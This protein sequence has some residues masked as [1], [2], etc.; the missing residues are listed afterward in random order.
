M[1]SF[2]RA[3]AG[4]RLLVLACLVLAGLFLALSFQSAATIGMIGINYLIP[5]GFW[6][7]LL[8]VARYSMVAPWWKNSMGRMLVALDLAVAL[9][10]LPSVLSTE[11]GRPVDSGFALRLVMLDLLIIPATILSRV[12]LLERLH[13]TRARRWGRSL[14]DRF[15]SRGNGR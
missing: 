6:S 5:V 3:L 12:W 10:L 15:R 8:F 13:D 9:A 11:F 4:Y 1:R 2:W 7:A 14:A